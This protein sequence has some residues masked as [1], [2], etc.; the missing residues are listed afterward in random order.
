MLK[1]GLLDPPAQVP[2]AKINADNE[3]EPWNSA[4]SHDISLRTALESIVLLKNDN[5]FLPLDPN[6]ERLSVLFVSPYPI[7]PPIHGGGVFM[8]QTATELTKLCDLHLVILLDHE[9]EE[10]AH[11]EPLS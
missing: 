6:P 7:C 5:R 11:A 3:P 10:P 4:H 8:Y 2:Y 9:W 1:L